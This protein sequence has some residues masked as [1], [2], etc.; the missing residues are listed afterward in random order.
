M[1]YKLNLE[2]TGFRQNLVP[3]EKLLYLWELN[4]L[5]ERTK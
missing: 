2:L 4:Y 1:Y 3:I 5:Y